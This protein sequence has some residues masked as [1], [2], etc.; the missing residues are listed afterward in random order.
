[1]SSALQAMPMLCSSWAA[2]NTLHASLCVCVCVCV[3][4]WF[5]ILILFVLFDF[6]S[7]LLVLGRVGGGKEYDQNIL[8]EKDCFNF[9]F[10]TIFLLILWGD[11][12]IVVV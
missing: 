8:Y 2:Q 1:M 3:C 5:F 11:F 4:V 12:H 10:N 6:L 7:L 9:F